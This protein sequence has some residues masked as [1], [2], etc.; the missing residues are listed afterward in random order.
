MTA[1]NFLFRSA[2]ITLVLALVVASC[3][4]TPLRSVPPESLRVD[5]AV[6]RQILGEGVHPVAI[7]TVENRRSGPVALSKTFGFGSHAWLGFKIETV[8]GDAVDY[9]MEIDLFRAP[10]YFCL[11]PGESLSWAINLLNWHVTVGGK[12]DD[13][14]AMAFDLAPGAYRLQALYSD[15]SRSVRAPCPVVEGR[16]ESGWVEFE[17]LGVD[18]PER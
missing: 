8:D 5:V 12:K 10:K 9:P 4:L 7:V 13:A 15:T 16:V 18:A 3:T 11:Y 1:P 17:V 2:Q 14:K 6:E